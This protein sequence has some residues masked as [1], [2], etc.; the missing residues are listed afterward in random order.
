M[1][2]NKAVIRPAEGLSISVYWY[3]GEGETDTEAGPSRMALQGM[4]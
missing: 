3:V 2:E 4:C 1:A